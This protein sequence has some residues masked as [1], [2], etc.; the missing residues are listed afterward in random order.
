MYRT[1]K[2]K[3]NVLVAVSQVKCVVHDSVTDFCNPTPIS[4][5]SMVLH[6]FE[7][8]IN[9]PLPLESMASCHVSCVSACSTRASKLIVDLS[10][11]L[12]ISAECFVWPNLHLLDFRGCPCVL[13]NLGMAVFIELTDI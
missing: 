9:D 13:S 10:D 4:S 1:R 6:Q 2:R 3:L 7:I 12:I 11:E 8:I 5:E